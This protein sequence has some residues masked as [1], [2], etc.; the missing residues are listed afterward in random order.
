MN[1]TKAAVAQAEKDREAQ[2]EMLCALI[3]AAKASGG[4]ARSCVREMKRGGYTAD[5]IA[6]A[7][8]MLLD[9]K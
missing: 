6:M 4:S 1:L 8:A 7:A 3:R 5:Q 9:E 2:L